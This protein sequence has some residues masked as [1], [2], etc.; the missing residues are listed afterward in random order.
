MRLTPFA[1]PVEDGLYMFGSMFQT[2]VHVQINLS[3]SLYM[4]GSIFQMGALGRRDGGTEREAGKG[5]GRG[6]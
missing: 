1:L 4:F 6:T 2:D 5:W 3:D